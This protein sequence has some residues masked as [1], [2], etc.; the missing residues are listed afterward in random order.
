MADS[1]LQPAWRRYV[2]RAPETADE[3]DQR[4]TMHA[5][6]AFLLA[7]AV[8][9]AGVFFL[10]VILFQETVAA[11][12]APPAAEQL[13]PS[14]GLALSFGFMAAILTGL[15]TG[16]VAF[17]LWSRLVVRPAR[18]GFVPGAGAGFL[19]ALLTSAVFVVVLAGPLEGALVMALRFAFPAGGELPGAILLLLPLVILACLAG[20]AL[21]GLLGSAQLHEIVQE[22]S[23]AP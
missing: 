18:F 2:A 14:Y 12:L 10:P 7:A 9:V 22:R 3:R 1:P 19:V 16:V 13:E 17:L 4:F 8:L 15:V 5:A 6:L 20:T 23:L 21:G 11:Y